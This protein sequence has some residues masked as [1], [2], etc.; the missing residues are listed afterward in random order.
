MKWLRWFEV[1]EEEIRQLV[2]AKYMYNELRAMVEDNTTLHQ[3]NPFFEYLARTYVSH[4]IIGV[5]RQ[6]KCNSQSVS[7]ARLLADLIKSPHVLTRAYFSGLY[8]DVKHRAYKDFENFA[9]P[10]CEHINPT[11]VLHDLARLRVKSRLCEQFADKRIAHRD[12]TPPKEL[13]TFNDLDACIDLLDDLCARYHLLFHGNS[14]LLLA[15]RQD[16]WKAIFR[17]PWVSSSENIT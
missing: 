10:G 12:T 4:A 5:R 2:A 11:L 9:L 16:D 13:P 3:N 6:I 15:T 17:I 1:I 7:F 8:K 14:T